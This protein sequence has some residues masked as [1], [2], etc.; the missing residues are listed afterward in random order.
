MDYTLKEIRRKNK[1]KAGVKPSIYI[2]ASIILS[3]KIYERR[4][5]LA[6]KDLKTEKQKLDN[7]YFCFIIFFS[8]HFRILLS[9]QI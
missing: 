3:H 2:V 6:K 4:D 9:L 7:Q 5:S 8:P 1:D